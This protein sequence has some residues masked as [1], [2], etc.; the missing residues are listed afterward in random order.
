[1]LEGVGFGAGA[2]LL[3][4][5]GAG[6]ELGGASVDEGEEPCE[7]DPPELDELDLLEGPDEPEP[8]AEG[9]AAWPACTV[10]W[11]P[12][13]A[14][15]F[16]WCRWPAEGAGV[17]A[18]DEEIEVEGCEPEAPV[19]WSAVWAGAVRANKVAKPTAATALSSVARQVSRERRRSP[20]ER[21]APGGSSGVSYS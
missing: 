19:D 20:A 9:T 12:D 15:P 5:A 18:A 7:P 13:A 14:C 3:D 4:G 1:M 10:G 8:P 11:T 6:A 21:A 2:E 17:P 16:L